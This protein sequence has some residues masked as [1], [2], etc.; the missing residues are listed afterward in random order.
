MSDFEAMLAEDMGEF[1]YDPLG[2]VMYA[3]DWGS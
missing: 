3:F 1:F 2:W